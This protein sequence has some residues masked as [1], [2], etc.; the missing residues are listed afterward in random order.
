M[1]KGFDHQTPIYRIMLETG[2]VSSRK[3][4]GVEH[5]VRAHNPP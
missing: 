2:G 1:E 4:P 3:T 5:A